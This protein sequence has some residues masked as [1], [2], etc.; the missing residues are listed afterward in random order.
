MEE[1]KTRTIRFSDFWNQLQYDIK[2][3]YDER[4]PNEYIT[5]DFGTIYRNS[6]SNSLQKL[7]IDS[8]RH[9]NYTELIFNS[10]KIMKNAA[11]YNI[12]IQIKLD[13]NNDEVKG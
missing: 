3:Y 11:Q 7:G 9:N 6:I 10:K 13:I 8:K 4:K 1:S 5:E 2:G 12:T